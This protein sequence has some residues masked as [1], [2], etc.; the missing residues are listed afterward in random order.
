MKITCRGLIGCMALLL[1]VGLSSC[2][3]EPDSYSPDDI[4]LPRPIPLRHSVWLEEL[5]WMEVRDLVATGTKTII[6]PSGAIEQTGPYLAIGKHNFIVRAMCESIA[7]KLGDTLCAPVVPFVP[8]G[9][10]SP[11]TGM[12]RY[13]GTISISDETF[14][15]LIVDIAESLAQH[16]FESVILISDNGGTQS[17]ARAIADFLRRKWKSRAVNAYFIP[18]YK[19]KSGLKQ[20]V[21]TNLKWV[22][23]NEGLHDDPRASTM[24]MTIDPNLVRIGERSEMGLTSIN[25]VSL[26]PIDEAIVAGQKIINY[27]VEN[28]VAAIRRAMSSSD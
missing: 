22:E 2:T 10:I 21:A 1:A 7:R 15:Q 23:R 9:N 17:H 3:S 8:H 13:P 12:M 14:K 5:T 20:W 28:T 18:E 25:D 16:G 24:L 27:R 4:D 26:L 11:P 19:D 6:I